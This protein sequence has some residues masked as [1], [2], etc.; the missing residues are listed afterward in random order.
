MTNTNED[1]VYEIAGDAWQNVAY[2][3][4]DGLALLLEEGSDFALQ[5]VADIMQYMDDD[6][7]FDQGIN[8]KGVRVTKLTA[9]VYPH[10]TLGCFG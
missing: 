5:S 7:H 2:A 1:D 6:V 3:I 4:S 10:Q 8:V 9:G